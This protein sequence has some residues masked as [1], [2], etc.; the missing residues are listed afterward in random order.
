V[1]EWKIRSDPGYVRRQVWLRDSGSCRA[2]GFDLKSAE[3]RWKREKPPRE[4]R[5]A[6]RRWRSTRPR[7]EADHI[8]PVADGGGE[9]GLENYRLLCRGCHAAVTR[10]WRRLKRVVRRALEE[11]SVERVS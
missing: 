8:L 5:A 1:H 7:W 2:C 11:V 10:Q 6:R 3:R 4:N 9:C